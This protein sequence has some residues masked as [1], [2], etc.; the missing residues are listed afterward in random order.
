MANAKEQMEKYMG[1]TVRV[2][3]S[4]G[5]VFE[6]QLQVRW[7]AFMTLDIFNHWILVAVHRQAKEHCVAGYD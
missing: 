6:G 3:I 2:R 5:R 7:L 1:G 4:T